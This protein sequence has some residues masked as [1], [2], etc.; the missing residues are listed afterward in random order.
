MPTITTVPP[1]LGKHIASFCD[2]D[3]QKK[4]RLV[5][6][7]LE[8][9]TTELVFE[10]CYVALFKHSVGSLLRIAKSAHLAQY[11]KS[12]TLY[13]NTMVWCGHDEFHRLC[14]WHGLDAGEKCTPG[15]CAYAEYVD[16][17]EVHQ[18]WT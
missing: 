14:D 11:V 17:Y 12:V 8:N 3:S 7:E 1:E 5:C 9:V 15:D 13:T 4:F 10:Q 16:M 6:R 2:H 18:G